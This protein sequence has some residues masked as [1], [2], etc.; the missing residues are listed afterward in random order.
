APTFAWPYSLIAETPG[1]WKKL[2]IGTVGE[3]WAIASVSMSGSDGN[4]RNNRVEAALHAWIYHPRFDTYANIMDRQPTVGGDPAS[5]E[6]IARKL[7]DFIDLSW[8][9]SHA[10]DKTGAAIRVTMDGYEVRS[11]WPA[12]TESAEYKARDA[13]MWDLYE[14]PRDTGPWLG[15]NWEIGKYCSGE[16]DEMHETSHLFY[17]FGDLYQYV[18]EPAL[19]SSPMLG[20]GRVPQIHSWVWSNQEHANNCNIFSEND[21]LGHIH[22]VG[23]RVAGQPGGDISQPGMETHWAWWTIAPAKVLIKVVDRAGN[24]VPNATVNL[25][26]QYD[27]A[28]FKTGTTNA[29]GIWD[30]G[31][32]YGET[33]VI[34]GT[35]NEPHYFSPGGLAGSG[36]ALFVTVDVNGYREAS[37]FGADGHRSHGAFTLLGAY[38]VDPTSYTWTFK[39]G[40][41]PSAAAMTAPVT[42]AVSGEDVRISVGG[43]GPYRLYRMLPP[44]YERVRIGTDGVAF[45]D[46]LAAEDGIVN[47]YGNPGRAT[48]EITSVS[49][50]TESLPL[51]LSLQGTGQMVGVTALDSSSSKLLVGNKPQGAGAL[52][53]VSIFDG[54][55]PVREYVY[56]PWNGHVAMKVV[57]SRLAPDRLYLSRSDHSE[58]SPFLDHQMDL[59]ETVPAYDYTRAAGPQSRSDI[60]FV[61]E[62]A[63][64]ITPTTV[65]KAGIDFI[66]RGVTKGDR[67]RIQEM[68]LDITDVTA[69]QIT[70]AAGG[71][72]S[73][74]DDRHFWV[75][76]NAGR[77]GTNY[78]ARQLQSVAGLATVDDAATGNEHVVI[79]DP[80]GGRVHFWNDKMRYV[81]SYTATGMKPTGLAKHPTKPGVV[82]V[83]DRGTTTRLIQ[84]KLSSGVATADVTQT[85]PGGNLPAAGTLEIGL[86]AVASG[87]DVLLAAVDATNNR[88]VEYKLTAAGV[89]SALPAYT[90]AL[91]PFVGSAALSDP[92]DVAYSV[93]G[94]TRNLFASDGS[95]S[96]LVLV[97][98]VATGGSGGTGGAGG[99]GGTGG[100]GGAG[101]TGGSVGGRGGAGGTGGSAGSGG[102]GGMA[103]SA[104]TGGAGGMGGASGTG[105]SSGLKVQYRTADINPA[106]NQAK[107]VLSVVNASGAAVPLSELKLRYWYTNEGGIAQTSY[108]DWAQ[109]N[110][111][112]VTRAFVPVS[113]T[114]PNADT[115]LEVGFTAAAGSVNAGAATGEIQLRMNKNDWSNYNESNDHSYDVTKTALADWSKVTLYR[116]G[117]LVWGTEP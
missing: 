102:T 28:V 6:Y 51:Q 87:T 60:P 15:G 13:D 53:F 108:C 43:T 80:V 88:I 82:F 110:C 107:P 116:N 21:V 92:R 37:V 18:V 16:S 41:A 72:N 29:S 46:N 30:T 85:V 40:Y 67:L 91:P 58:D 79:A 78:T 44:A 84:L 1:Q 3:R 14:G 49:G 2:N 5:R 113:P 33:P 48:Y 55:T 24:P 96:R 7:A 10:G 20:N 36:H 11:E 34:S 27:T 26:R 57:P 105:G 109:V 103:G 81:T 54:T 74:V 56:H 98:S 86:A 90:S 101:G 75:H 106:D 45:S 64:S 59:Y 65:T 62:I 35:S 97:A 61:D 9:R 66:A 68:D 99:A 42:A 100:R 38:H 77:P 22:L 69:T 52:T 93:V 8:A 76:L 25:W 70:A 71:I 117:V 32:P 111:A 89:L 31:H 47:V 104:G 39:T 19:T 112:N 95:G 94:N 17:E 73:T 115:Y 63:D 114:R 12:D 23:M 83:L 50:A 4:P